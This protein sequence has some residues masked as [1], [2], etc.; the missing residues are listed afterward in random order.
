LK[1]N[2]RILDVGCGGGQSAKFLK[3][4]RS[5]IYVV[6]VEPYCGTFSSQMDRVY[7]KSI[8]AFLESYVDEPFDVILC[9]D[10]LEHIWNYEG[11][12]K[13]LMM[14]LKP[15]GTLLISVPNVS[16][17]RVFFEIIIK[18][19]FPKN[20]EGIFDETH[21]RWFTSRSLRNDLDK[22]DLNSVKISFSGLEKG[23]LLYYVNLFTFRLL[24]RFL[25]FQ[26]IAICK[27]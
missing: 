23:K 22:L 17:F 11:T 25:G 15:G 10:V 19:N 6:G 14:I 27:K 4:K 20:E 7:K 18:N 16:N 21:C 1:E 9:L 2:Y 12:L 26:V 13:D 5:D 3:M 24:Q 8:T